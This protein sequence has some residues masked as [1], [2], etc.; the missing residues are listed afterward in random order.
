MSKDNASGLPALKVV[1]RG[2]LSDQIS[3]QL[4]EMI[5]TGEFP[6]GTPLPS[7]RTIA[8]MTQAS[9][10]AVREAISSLV[11]KRIVSVKQG[12]GTYVN[13]I[14]EWNTL[15]PHVLLL[16]H[17][18]EAI[19][20]LMEFRMMLEPEIVAKAAERIEPDEIEQLLKLSELPAEDTIDQHAVRDNEFHLFLAKLTGNTVLLVVMNSIE[21]LMHVN[22]RKAFVVPGE[23]AKA[24][25]WHTAIA[26]AV[27]EHNPKAARMAMAKH[28]R[29]VTDAIEI[30]AQRESNR[31]DTLTKKVQAWE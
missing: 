1:H 20:H 6:A 2:K 15:D 4:L 3:Q 17:G 5:V 29:Q 25:D 12:K 24:R 31:E 11:G 16:L 13:P 14:D 27:A 18:Q 19:R 8:E 26:Q 28:L 7:E 10:V 30:E 22:R 21:E 23:L 9:R